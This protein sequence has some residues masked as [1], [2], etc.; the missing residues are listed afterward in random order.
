M[1]SIISG[2]SIECLSI[3]LNVQCQNQSRQCPGCPTENDV[4]TLLQLFIL[5]A[6]GQG[7]HTYKSIILSI[8]IYVWMVSFIISSEAKQSAVFMGIRN[9]ALHCPNTRSGY[10]SYYTLAQ[11]TIRHAFYLCSQPSYLHHHSKIHLYPFI[12]DF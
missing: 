9:P 8:L 12:I 10:H 5:P 4:V 11:N 7:H 2:K 1:L 3:I 6:N